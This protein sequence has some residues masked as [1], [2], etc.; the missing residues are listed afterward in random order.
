MPTSL[1]SAKLLGVNREGFFARVQQLPDG[2]W[3]WTR[4]RQKNGYGIVCHNGAA[5]LAHSVAWELLR[6]EIPP[7]KRLGHMCSN[8]ACCN[9]KHLSLGKRQPG[10][11]RIYAHIDQ[12]LD[13]AF[14]EPNTGC[15]LWPG[16]GDQDGYGHV[17]HGRKHWATHRLA[18]VLVHGHIP[19]GLCVCHKCDTPA[20]INP[21]HLFVGTSAENIFDRHR[22]GRDAV[23]D[24]NGSRARPET[25]PRGAAN[26]R[27]KFTSEKVAEMKV[28]YASGVHQ[29]EL[30]RRYGVTPSAIRW[31]L[32]GWNWS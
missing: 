2:C 17:E 7:G 21:T 9:P 28:A 1:P 20:C 18:W 6:G 14:A 25:R 19:E 30:A 15:W 5:R 10:A 23:G 27:S 12:L 8:K 26:G 22:K 31:I 29:A 3:E 32:R 4:G 11:A 13:R 16:A 24:Q